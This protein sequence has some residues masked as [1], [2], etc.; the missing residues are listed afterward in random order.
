MV[1]VF[2][3]ERKIIPEDGGV[4]RV[5]V[6]LSREFE[7]RGHKVRF[8]SLGPREMNAK[9]ADAGFPQDYIPLDT[10]GR[11][12]RIR[13]YMEEFK[14]DL[15]IIQSY[16]KYVTSVIP[17]I[18]AGI[19][20]LLV[21]HNQPYSI[22]G[23]ER[24][25][26]RLTPWKSLSMRGKV[27]RALATLS[28]RLFRMLDMRHKS[29]YIRTLVGSVDKFVLL[30][31][32]FRPRLIE[33]TPGINAENVV[34]INNPNTFDSPDVVEST[35]KE[36]LVVFVGRLNNQQKNVT[37]FIKVWKKFSSLFPEWKA[38][39]VG[40]GEDRDYVKKY[41]ARLGVRNLEFTGV[42]KDVEEFYKRGKILCLTSAYEGWGM[43]LVEAMAYGCVPVIYNSYEAAGDI[44][45]SG[46]NGYLIPPYN[47]EDMAKRMSELASNEN[48]R[49]RLAEN[50]RRKIEN[51]TVPNIADKW[52]EL[53][54]NAIN[55]AGKS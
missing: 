34:A 25:V 6:L 16:H 17:A 36:N 24:F 27:L 52:E 49:M 44:I 53:F 41:A 43:V 12:E 3:Y 50:G 40:D 9:E 18:P 22:L 29:A 45:E 26:K 37:G 20:K 55:K 1:I 21:Y 23:Q 4:E 8:L 33:N 7:R 46:A 19:K 5:T 15:V 42:R 39:I 54:S 47:S 2:L 10:E 32:K 35:N 51:F 13:E 31:E 30:S 28:P 48:L 38:V 11:L 14:P